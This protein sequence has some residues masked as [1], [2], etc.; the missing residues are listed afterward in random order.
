ML[1]QIIPFQ[2]MEQ[3]KFSSPLSVDDFIKK[4]S[5]I[6]Y[7]KEALEEV[8]DTIVEISDSEGLT[9]HSNSIKIRF[10]EA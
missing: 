9:A 5:L 2:L 7:S 4:T 3:P 1:D 8:K 10:E 6:Y